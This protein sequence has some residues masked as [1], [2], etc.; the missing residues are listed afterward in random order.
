MRAAGSYVD[1]VQGLAGCHEEPVSARA[2]EADVGA[3]LGQ[4]DL[5]NALS[6]RREDLDTVIARTAAA[7]RRRGCCTTG[8]LVG[9]RASS[10][11]DGVGDGTD[12]IMVPVEMPN[13]ESPSSM[14]CDGRM[15][16][17]MPS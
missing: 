5:A 13:T 11:G 14:V 1:G 4:H 6:G 8:A 12:W 3:D 10:V 15:P 7:G 2:A 16:R 17:A 9:D